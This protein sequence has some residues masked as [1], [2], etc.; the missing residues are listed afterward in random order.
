MIINERHRIRLSIF[1][2]TSFDDYWK[3]SI[4]HHARDL[5]VHHR[6]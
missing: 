3:N 1:N 4:T 6:I 2:K 5:K